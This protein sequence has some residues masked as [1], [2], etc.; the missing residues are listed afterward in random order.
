MRLVADGSSI[1]VVTSLHLTIPDAQLR[2][3]FSK[4]FWNWL[5]GSRKSA[6]T[7]LKVGTSPVPAASRITQTRIFQTF[8][9]NFLCG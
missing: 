7:Y 9:I 6:N 1:V 5:E 8:A 4:R 2:R 3:K